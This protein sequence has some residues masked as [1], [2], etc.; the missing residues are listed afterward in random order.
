VLTDQL[1]ATLRFD[2]E[3]VGC[4]PAGI[5]VA[6]AAPVPV[7]AEPQP[8]A[9]GAGANATAPAQRASAVDNLA[10]DFMG[11]GPWTVRAG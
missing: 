7:A 11:D 8:A 4:A 1:T 10:A 5:D 2:T 6:F 9:A 3:T